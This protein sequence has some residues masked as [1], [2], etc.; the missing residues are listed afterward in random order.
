MKRFAFVAAL[1]VAIGL[2]SE[3]TASA[4]Y[5]SGYTVI[6]PNGGVV[7]TNQVQTFGAVRQYSTYVSPFGTVQK[8]AYYG[9]VFG[10]SY[11][12]AA[13]YNAFTG[14]G[15]NRGFYTTG[16]FLPTYGGY[17]YGFYRRW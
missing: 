13:G 10:N 12:R 1:A 11:G 15:Y 2:G 5:V 17:N 14:Y 7:R 8:Q 4:Q 3:G 9:D 6:T 16:P